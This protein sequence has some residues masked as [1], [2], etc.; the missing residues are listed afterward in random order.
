[1][2][3]VDTKHNGCHF[4]LTDDFDHVAFVR[5]RSYRFPVCWARSFISARAYL[6]V[7][8]VRFVSIATV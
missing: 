5:A 6:C 3:S 4:T 7:Y 2:L 1:M 8:L